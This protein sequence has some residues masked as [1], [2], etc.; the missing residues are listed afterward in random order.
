MQLHCQWMKL[1]IENRLHHRN[2][3][4]HNPQSSAL[5]LHQCHKQQYR[6]N[7]VTVTKRDW[8]G[9]HSCEC[10]CVSCAKKRQSLS[11]LAA[12]VLCRNMY[13]GYVQLCFKFNVFGYWP[14]I[15][16]AAW[17]LFLMRGLFF[18]CTWACAEEN[19]FLGQNTSHDFTRAD[20]N[21]T[22]H[23]C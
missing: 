11:F 2:H 22:R 6:G 10:G 19:H 7:I 20:E 21:Q 18:T 15:M 3:H 12:Q 1:L 8:K 5:H 14:G 9:W 23:F 13:D 16:I 17:E 4:H